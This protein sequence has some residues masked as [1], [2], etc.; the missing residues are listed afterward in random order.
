VETWR[1]TG[2]GLEGA[3]AAHTD[4]LLC[5][6]ELQEVD[7]AEAGKTAYLLANGRGKIRMRDSTALRSSLTWRLLFLSSG[8]LSL[9]DHVRE[10]GKQ[11]RAG[12]DLRIADIPADAGVGLGTWER[13][14]GDT[15][16]NAFARSLEA[17]VLAQ[18][19]T[20]GPAFLSSLVV[21]LDGACKAVCAYR[22]AFTS[23]QAP[24]GAA[25]QVLRVAG[26]FALVAAGGELATA[27][28]VTGWHQGEAYRA[29]AACFQAW[30]MARPGGHGSGE[31]SKALEQV[32]SFILAHGSSSFEPWQ[33]S[34]S[35]EPRTTQRVGWWRDR[36]GQ[37]EYLIPS[38]VWRASV[39]KGLDAAWVSAELL[40]L[41]HLMADPNGKSSQ[42]LRV[43]SL[44][45][46]ARLYVLR[47]SVIGGEP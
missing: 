28:G 27:A 47:S 37:R 2:N 12:M 16:G 15:D 45:S 13:L 36:D 7:G 3:A 5:L 6:D 11:T 9:A 25:G 29:A 34:E 41:G 26:R 10:A 18:R 31:I 44:G 21:D 24:L 4:G 38:K 23:E 14:H 1:A 30:L 32:G 42:S 20:A 39:C 17:A 46:T 40:K 33:P 22:D 8:E 35:L 43:P 19:G